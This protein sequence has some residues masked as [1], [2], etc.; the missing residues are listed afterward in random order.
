[1]SLINLSER[2]KKELIKFKKYL[3]FKSLQVI[4][5]SRSGRKL[6][7]QSKLISSGSDWFNL[8]VRDDSK[9]V[10]EIKK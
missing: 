8:S 2:D 5:Q 9:V 3:V 7:A 6:V 4:L 10:D 1:M